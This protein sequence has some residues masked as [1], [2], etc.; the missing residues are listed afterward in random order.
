MDVLSNTQGSAQAVRDA[1][2]ASEAV[3]SRMALER[4]LDR[5]NEAL[6]AHATAAAQ[7]LNWTLLAQAFLL[8]SYLIVLVGGWSVPLPGKR[9]LLAAIV[10]YGAISLVLGYLS[11]RGSRDRLA[12]LRNSQRLVEQ[13]LERVANR[14]TVFSRERRLVT[15]FGDWATRLLPVLIL[16]GWAALTL[17]TLALPI[18]ADGRNAAAARSDTRTAASTAP[19]APRART[20]GRKV[21]ETAA[22]SASAEAGTGENESGLAALFRR[23]INASQ[24][25]APQGE[26]SAESVKP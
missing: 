5:L 26:A 15:T 7:H 9:W 14:P 24:T 4:E 19:A 25:E 12:P 23:A 17:Y 20:P 21:E 22:A 13:A 18:P 11:Q 10:G 3:D 16:A 8:T 6:G 1:A 2:A